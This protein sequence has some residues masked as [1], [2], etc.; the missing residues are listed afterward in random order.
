[1]STAIALHRLGHDDLADRFVS[2]A[3]ANDPNEMMGLFADRLEAAG[4]PTT[5]FDYG[6]DLVTVIAE[7]FA[8]ADR[9]DGIEP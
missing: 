3:Y 5:P 4:L 9:L 2:W 1:M 6:H 7:V 8:V